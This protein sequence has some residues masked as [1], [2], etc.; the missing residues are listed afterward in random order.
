MMN[1]QQLEEEQDDIIIAG[2][3]DNGGNS[4]GLEEKQEEDRMWTIGDEIRIINVGECRIGNGSA[5]KEKD[6]EMFIF[7]DNENGG[8]EPNEL[9]ARGVDRLERDIQFKEDGK[10]DGNVE[11]EEGCN[12][13]EIL[14][15]I[16][17]DESDTEYEFVVDNNDED[18]NDQGM[19]DEMEEIDENDGYVGG[20]DD[21]DAE[22][23]GRNDDANQHK[24]DDGNENQMMDIGDGQ[25]NDANDD[26]APD[27]VMEFDMK[28]IIKDIDR[29][30]NDKFR[31]ELNEF[32]RQMDNIIGVGW[33]K[34]ND[35]TS[36]IAKTLKKCL[37]K[38]ISVLCY[39]ERYP[40]NGTV[41][42]AYGEFMKAYM[43]G[44]GILMDFIIST[45]IKNK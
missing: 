14:P 26:N 44:W 17:L 24:C 20:D 12:G 30:W 41:R 13:N 45:N 32:E 22:I 15:E 38:K 9:L 34:R 35:T 36:D 7:T 1:H 42:K 5:E 8:K 27:V 2:V 31:K 10:K 6:A 29:E 16:V 18:A 43:T 28:K 3:E 23:V 37:I 11:V 4:N 25:D 33:Y 39:V 19:G 40:D 21:D